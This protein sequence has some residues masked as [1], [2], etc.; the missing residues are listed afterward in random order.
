MIFG[1]EHLTFQFMWVQFF[2]K[3]YSEL[4]P[5]G[6]KVFMHIGD[7]E[8]G[9]SYLNYCQEGGHRDLEDRL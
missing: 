3:T 9:Y 2:T 4:L 7:A 8:G 5:D 6:A 1:W